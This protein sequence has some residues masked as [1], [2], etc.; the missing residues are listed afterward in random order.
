MLNHWTLRPTSHISFRRATCAGPR[1]RSGSPCPS[2]RAT[3]RSGAGRSGSQSC[4]SGGPD[5]FASPPS[6]SPIG[7]NMISAANLADYNICISACWGPSSSEGPQKTWFNNIFQV[8]HVNR[9]LRT[10]AK[11]MHDVKSMIVTKVGVVPK[12]RAGELRLNGGKRNW[13]KEEKAI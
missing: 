3:Y 5:P 6:T 1:P 8:W 12:L 2:S 7:M 11:S 13:L 9:Y 10:Q 4:T